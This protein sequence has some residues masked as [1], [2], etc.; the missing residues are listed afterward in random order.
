[1]YVCAVWGYLGVWVCSW[2]FVF[3]R[4]CVFVGCAVLLCVTVVTLLLLL[5]FSDPTYS[6]IFVVVYTR[7]TS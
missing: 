7:K 6:E 2:Y 5:L 1:M 3:G 4:M